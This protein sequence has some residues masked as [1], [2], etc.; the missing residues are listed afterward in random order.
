[1]F[2]AAPAIRASDARQKD[3]PA[4]TGQKSHERPRCW[5]RALHRPARP[6]KEDPRLLTAVAS[7]VDD[8]AVPGMLHV[9]F[10]RSSIARGNILSIN[11]D[12][13]REVPGVHAVY[14]QE[15]LA[16]FKVD[17][18][19]F[20]FISSEVKLTPLASGRVAYVGE[21]VALVIADSRYIAEDGAS[22]VEIEYAE[23]DPVVT[24]GR[25][26]APPAGSS[27]HRK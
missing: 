24:I 17:M 15:D 18:M 21:P 12:V 8:I 16:R 11:T 22:L 3:S 2:V 13:A 5:N 14:T 23:E 26:A 20:F 7:F 10:A 19:N 6:Q 1:M 4:L 27:R 25:R 9:A